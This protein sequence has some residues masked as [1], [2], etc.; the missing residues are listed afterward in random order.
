MLLLLT[1]IFCTAGIVGVIA[2]LM[3]MGK[4][5]RKSQAK[6]LLWVGLAI[7][8]ISFLWVIAVAASSSNSN[9]F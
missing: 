9:S 8:A 2:G 5:A 4:P 6:V 3:N 1:S 7:M